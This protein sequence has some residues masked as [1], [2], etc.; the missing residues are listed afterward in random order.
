VGWGGADDPHCRKPMVWKDIEPYDDPAE[1]VR[2][3]MLE[4]YRRLIAIRRTYPAL[5]VGELRF[6][7][8][9]DAADAFA[10]VRTL[11]SQSILVVINNSDREQG[12]AIPTDAPDDTAF[13][14]LLSP[15]AARLVPSSGPASSPCATAPAG[16]PATAAGRP[17]IELLPDAPVAARAEAGKLR[18][19]LPPRSGAI[20]VAKK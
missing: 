16:A 7:L 19:A 9:D 20:L 12:V 4:H 11:G 18:L 15:K 14:D 2:E 8:A 3:D 13:V 6:V 17:C 10:Y 1:H 5:R